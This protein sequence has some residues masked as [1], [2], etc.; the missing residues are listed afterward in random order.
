MASPP[1][2]S[3]AVEDLHWTTAVSHMLHRCWV[4][5]RDGILGPPPGTQGLSPAR[6]TS[7]R[8]ELSTWLELEL[9]PLTVVAEKGPPHPPFRTENPV[10]SQ[11]QSS[12]ASRHG[13]GISASH[14]GAPTLPRKSTQPRL[15][16]SHYPAGWVERKKT[17]RFLLLP[18]LPPTRPGP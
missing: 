15:Q 14:P 8:A 11:V 16:R 1:C 3:L 4:S 13:T 17:T 2:A 6:H 7:R 12:P 9:C 18:P 5:A 10:R